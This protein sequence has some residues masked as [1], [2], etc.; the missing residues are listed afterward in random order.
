MRSPGWVRCRTTSPTPN[1]P[2]RH[3]N[4]QRAEERSTGRRDW[5]HGITVL[6][7]PGARHT[8]DLK[9]I[10]GIGTKTE[11]ALSQ[12]GI[13]TWEQISVLEE[14]DIELV[15]QAI[16]SFVDRIERDA[17]VEQAQDLIE[18]FPHRD[19]RPTKETLINSDS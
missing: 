15:A 8:D 18:R 19:Q 10:S 13:R 7:T 14:T 6:G 2:H 3:S 17:W 1:P 11:I 5:Q 9:V 12:L 16:D 4:G